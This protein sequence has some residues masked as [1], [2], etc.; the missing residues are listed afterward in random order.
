MRCLLTRLC[1]DCGQTYALINFPPN[2]RN[3]SGRAVRCW[4]CQRAYNRNWY[5][6]HAQGLKHR[7]KKANAKNYQARKL[8][9][10]AYLNGKSCIDC[11]E[12]DPVVLEFDHR[13]GE[14]KEFDVANAGSYSK[15]RV[16]AELAK[17]DV[18]CANCHRR[19]TAAQFGYYK[20]RPAY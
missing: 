2:R 16:A 12:T 11:G 8:Q 5:H 14:S 10:F 18:R 19:K 6:K 20:Y 9:V 7:K 1:K 4:A 3:R 13:D 17:C 15:A